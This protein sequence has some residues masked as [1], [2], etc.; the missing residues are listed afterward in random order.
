MT[1]PA[2]LRDVVPAVKEHIAETARLRE[3]EPEILNAIR[4]SLTPWLERANAA[5]QQ[6]QSDPLLSVDQGAD[7]AAKAVIE[8]LV[9]RVPLTPNG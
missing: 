8:V 2:I 4:A 7:S 1:N 5:L 6:G 9:S 3:L